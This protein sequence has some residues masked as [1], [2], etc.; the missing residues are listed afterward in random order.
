MKRPTPSDAS[1]AAKRSASW[2]L[3]PTAS[4]RIAGSASATY[5]ALTGSS[6]RDMPSSPHRIRSANDAH[7]AGAGVDG[8]LG[9][10][11]RV[12]RLRQDRVRREERDEAELVGHHSPGDLVAHHQ[13]GAEQHRDVGLQR[14]PRREPEQPAQLAVDR[15]EGRAQTEPATA[16]ARPS[17]PP[18]KPT[19]PSVPPMASTSFSRRGEV[20]VGRRTVHDRGTIAIVATRITVLAI[21]ATATITNRRLA[22]STAVATVPTA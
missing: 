1:A 8:E 9:E 21:G 10:D 2:R 3:L 15:A 17:A 18:T 4:T 16:G 6:S 22:N 11:R 7:V 14:D 20:E 5:A 13:R 12:D 19:T